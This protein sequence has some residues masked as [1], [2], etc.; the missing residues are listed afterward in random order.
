MDRIGKVVFWLQIVG[1]GI[2]M[3]F[4]AI[5]YVQ[6]FL[7][8]N[9]P[10]ILYQIKYW[11]L[12][13][14]VLVVLLILWIGRLVW[15]DY[16]RK[17]FHPILRIS[18]YGN[19]L[20]SI[21][22]EFTDREGK[23]A[24]GYTSIYETLFI[25]I[26]NKQKRGIAK[27]VWADIEWVKMNEENGEV[28]VSHRG[29]W[30]LATDTIKNEKV[31]ENLQY[32]DFDSNRSI[33]KLYFAHTIKNDVNHRWYGLER[34]MNGNDLWGN[35]KNELSAKQYIVRITLRGN[36]DVI[37]KFKYKVKNDEG[38]ISIVEALTNESKKESF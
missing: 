26:F 4:E 9:T 14:A 23:Q 16:Q 10:D 27:R 33:Q 30:H 17:S 32:L 1:T 35:L 36:D 22:S 15:E 6:L 12:V 5:G 3:I 13:N 8:N 18:N 24:V 11:A 34:D 7:S 28:E 19:D 2:A 38:R 29:R 37:Q 31:R 20:K 25:E 21:Y